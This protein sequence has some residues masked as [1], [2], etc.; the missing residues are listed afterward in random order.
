MDP[1]NG[2]GCYIATSHLGV[3]GV[4]GFCATNKKGTSD[5]D[6]DPYQES[7]LAPEFS[8][9]F[10]AKL[11][12]ILSGA[13]RHRQVRELARGLGALAWEQLEVSTA[14]DTVH[15]LE[16][17]QRPLRATCADVWRVPKKWGG[18]GGGG[19]GGIWDPS[20]KKCINS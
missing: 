9:R 2:L 1:K 17:S 11:Q 13:R 8:P 5:S 15:S 14:G 7:L 6:M 12:V 10:L 16:E 20:Q 19:G 4:A 18:G 3:G